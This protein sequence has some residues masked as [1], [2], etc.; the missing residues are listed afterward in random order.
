MNWRASIQGKIIVP[1][2]QDVLNYLKIPFYFDK[3]DEGMI[4]GDYTYFMQDADPEYLRYI[5]GLEAHVAEI[6]KNKELSYEEEIEIRKKYMKK[7][8][9]NIW[10]KAIG[11]SLNTVPDSLH[12]MKCNTQ[13]IIK[14]IISNS[15]IYYN[16]DNNTITAALAVFN[17]GLVNGQWKK[18]YKENKIKKC[19][20]NQNLVL[21]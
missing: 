8:K 1:T 13:H 5:K 18:Y 21:I 17:D 6:A 19:Q 20:K 12:M 7:A 2:R 11:N 14:K 16:I 10:R 15:F 9:S 3:P 4:G